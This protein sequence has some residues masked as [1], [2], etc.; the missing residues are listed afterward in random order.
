[1]LD[2]MQKQILRYAG[3]FLVSV[4][5]SELESVLLHFEIADA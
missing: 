2:Q 1:M 3:V 4:R 5:P